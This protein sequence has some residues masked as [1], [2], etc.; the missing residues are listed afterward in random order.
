[1]VTCGPFCLA[2]LDQICIEGGGGE[3]C[4]RGK[5]VIFSNNMRLHW[6]SFA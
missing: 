4:P 3:L 5:V 1:M 6:T 2:V